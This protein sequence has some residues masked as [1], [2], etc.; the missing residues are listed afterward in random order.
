[1]GTVK[2]RDKLAALCRVAE[3]AADR[4][5]LP[6][7]QAQA[8]VAQ[9]EADVAAIRAHHAKLNTECPDPVLAAFAAQQTNRLRLAQAGA[10]QRLAERMAILETHKAAARPPVGRRHV[11]QALLDQ[12][13]RKARQYPRG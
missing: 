12:E 5:L 7:A 8:R 10:M 9:A 13:N 1:M 11:L 3:L 6:V 2:R 4:A